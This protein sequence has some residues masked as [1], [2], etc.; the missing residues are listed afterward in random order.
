MEQNDFLSSTKDTQDSPAGASPTARCGGRGRKSF[1]LVL[2]LFV[3]P[4]EHNPLQGKDFLLAEETEGL[5]CEW[6][7]QR[8][9]WWLALFARIHSHRFFQR[10]WSFTG[11][12]FLRLLQEIENW[13][14]VLPDAKREF[15][16][17]GDNNR[18]GLGF[19]VFCF[20]LRCQA[21]P[22]QRPGQRSFHSAG[23]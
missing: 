5:F 10:L 1:K 4:P 17:R 7:N 23:A 2:V 18:V 9:N 13:R 19:Q 15:L 16:K 21:S 6:G 12:G 3:F 22:Q 8:W 11:T 20:I 14:G